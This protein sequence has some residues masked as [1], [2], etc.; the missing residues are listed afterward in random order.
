MVTVW[1]CGIWVM[2]ACEVRCGVW[3]YE[4]LEYLRVGRNN[5]I[6]MVLYLEYLRNLQMFVDNSLINGVVFVEDIHAAE[7]FVVKEP[8]LDLM[9]DPSII[10]HFDLG[11]I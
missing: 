4:G 3:L 8:V 9:V 6:P 1:G 2:G 11:F 5:S 10:G 7:V